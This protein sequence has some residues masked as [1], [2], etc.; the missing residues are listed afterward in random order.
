MACVVIIKKSPG[1]EP[2]QF[3][4]PNKQLETDK[5]S[6]KTTKKQTTV[7]FKKNP[8]QA[9]ARHNYYIEN[10]F[11]KRITLN[12]ETDVVSLD[13]GDT[14]IKVWHLYQ[15]SLDTKTIEYFDYIS[16]L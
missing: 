7:L 2:Q 16:S 5:L 10:Y 1:W 13:Y 3:F 4:L 8:Q 9:K 6:I 14:V 11:N 12:S 15:N